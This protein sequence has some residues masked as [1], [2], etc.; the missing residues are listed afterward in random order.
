MRK[1]LLATAVS[2]LLLLGTVAPSFADDGQTLP[3]TEQ[4]VTAEINSEFNR[5]FVDEN[6]VYIPPVPTFGDGFANL[7]ALIDMGT[8]LEDAHVDGDGDVVQ[9]TSTGLAYWLPADNQVSFTDGWNRWAWTDYGLVQWAGNDVEAPPPPPVVATPVYTSPRDYLYAVA[10]ASIAR[11]LD[12]IVSRESG[13]NPNAVNRSSGASG[14]FQFLISTW[15]ITPPG[16]AGYSVFDPYRNIDGGIWLYLNVG[17]SQWEVVLR[18][19]C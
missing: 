16:R 18:G 13:W 19:Y 4:G 3:L 5:Q 17:A 9:L 10:P 7:S 8:P 6:T 12:C 1:T 14:L 15:R 2:A 11:R